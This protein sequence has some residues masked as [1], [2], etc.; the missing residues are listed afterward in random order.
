MYTE[1]LH[2]KTGSFLAAV[3]ANITQLSDGTIQDIRQLFKT[4]NDLLWFIIGNV[5]VT[6][7]EAL[8]LCDA[9]FP[10]YDA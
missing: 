1:T 5:D 3:S 8:D 9:V 7:T 2:D 4:H 6:W 10:L